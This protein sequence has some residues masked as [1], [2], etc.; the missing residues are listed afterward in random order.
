MS[1]GRDTAR[2]PKHLCVHVP[3]CRLKCAYCDFF[4][5]AVFDLPMSTAE[6]AEVLSRANLKLPG[7][8]TGAHAPGPRRDG[9]HRER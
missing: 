2:T 6:L 3:V 1:K 8:P 4:S 7:S 5:V 9:P